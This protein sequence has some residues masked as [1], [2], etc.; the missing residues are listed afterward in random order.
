MCGRAGMY[1]SAL[2]FFVSPLIPYLC[3][4]INNNS[5]T[6]IMINKRNA[7]LCCSCNY[8]EDNRY[9]KLYGR[10]ESMNSFYN[11]NLWKD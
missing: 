5:K 2:F 11:K 9:F 4:N 8:S 7:V 3:E 1:F 10:D 6:S